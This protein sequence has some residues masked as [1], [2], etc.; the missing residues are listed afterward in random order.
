MIAGASARTAAGLALLAAVTAQAED[1]RFDVVRLDGSATRESEQASASLRVAEPVVAGDRVRTGADGHIV[2]HLPPVGALTLGVESALYV[3]SIEAEDL[4]ARSGLARLILEYG[5]ARI[6]A[7]SQQQLPPADLRINMGALRLRVFGAEIWIERSNDVEEVCLLSGAIELQGPFG[8]RRLDEPGYCLRAAASGLLEQ[9]ANS[10]SAMAPRLNLTAFPGDPTMQW[11]ASM[12]A[13]EPRP[14][15]EAGARS[16][17]EQ[18]LEPVPN[19]ASSAP[20]AALTAE[21]V[22]EPAAPLVSAPDEGIGDWTIV[23]AS[24]PEEAAAE[25]EAARLRAAGLDARLMKV[26][27][28]EG[29]LTYRV[30]SGQYPSKSDAAPAIQAIRARRGLRAAWI[31]PLQ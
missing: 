2:L 15:A 22:A 12:A 8:S 20:A 14:D 31:A 3:H 9:N 19:A 21:P 18:G 16:R 17:P 26:A 23:L 28:D 4:P 5:T 10:A 24:L 13:T 29:G 27:R 30:V 6:N 25:K 7:R 11:V 1:R